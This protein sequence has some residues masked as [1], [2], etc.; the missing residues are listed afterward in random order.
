MRVVTIHFLIKDAQGS[1]LSRP[2]CDESE[3][4]P[5]MNQKV[6]LTRHGISQYLDLITPAFKTMKNKSFINYLVYGILLQQPKI[7]ET[8]TIQSITIPKPH[9]RYIFFKK[10]AFK[11]NH[12]Q[13]GLSIKCPKYNGRKCVSF[14]FQ[15]MSLGKSNKRIFVFNLVVLFAVI[16]ENSYFFKSECYENPLFLMRKCNYLSRYRR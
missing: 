12:M 16:W 11:M 15:I 7:T 10:L 3:K 9:I 8:G 4:E 5:S 13:N 6:N 14:V 1:H 2:P